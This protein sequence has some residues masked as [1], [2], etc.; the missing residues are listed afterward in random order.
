MPAAPADML[1]RQPAR[2][3]TELGLLVL[4]V[5]VTLSADVLAGLGSTGHLPRHLI[6][7]A[8]GLVVL[9]GVA[10]LANRRYAPEAD[11]VLLPIAGFLNGLG[12]V[13]IDRLDKDP[14]I[15]A[16][17]G[18]GLAFHQALWSAI[19]IGVYVATVIAI[20]RSRDLERYRFLLALA[21]AVLLVL[22][23][24][25]FIGEDLY[26]ARLWIHL[27]PVSFQPVELAKI[28]F[29]IFLASWFVEKRELFQR[30]TARVGR[31][32]VPDPRPLGPVLVAW[33]FAM[34]AM[35]AEHNVGFALLIFVIF[36]S[37]LWVATGR[38]AYIGLGAVLFVLG[39]VV[40]DALLPQVSQRITIWLHPW[41]HA[42]TSAYQIVQSLYAFGS[43][44]IAGAGLGLG[45]P[46]Y[47]PV[48]V[49]DFIFAAIGDEL[50]LIGATAIVVA[51]LLIV[52]SGL[53]IALAAR[54]DFARLLATGLTITIGFQAFFIMAGVVR[55]LPLTGVTLPFV[56]YGGSSLVANYLLLG[57][58]NRIA[59]EGQGGGPPGRRLRRRAS[60][61]LPGPVGQSRVGEDALS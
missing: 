36:L 10:H 58:L 1:I 44:G 56:A 42:T 25:P 15:R 57:I 39:A 13:L 59:D 43:G 31:L 23:L 27:G 47:V 18:S 55:L 33:A 35:T 50:G 54:S 17:Y 45:H 9:L 30:P 14:S 3:R 51:F 37:M 61:P 28:A 53:R 26:G 29:A 4:V 41:A 48:V 38:L 21:G 16:T 7:L 49:S 20:Q 2:R 22:P 46:A 60:V 40:G 11:P 6:D 12:W 5:V 52:G 19:G 24:A 32:L 8:V 34:L